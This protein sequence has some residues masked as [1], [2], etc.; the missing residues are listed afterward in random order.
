MEHIKFWNLLLTYLEDS[1][2]TN[3]LIPSE[4]QRRLIPKTMSEQV[5]LS[6]Y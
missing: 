1:A 4:K 2:K 6:Q 5:A 3:S